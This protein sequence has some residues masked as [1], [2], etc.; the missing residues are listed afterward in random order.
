MP[1]HNGTCCLNA[2]RHYLVID[3]RV[4]RRSMDADP[5]IKNVPSVFPFGDLY[6]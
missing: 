4:I 3:I 1:I 6:R 5:R 2:A